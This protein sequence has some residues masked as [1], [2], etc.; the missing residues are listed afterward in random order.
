MNKKG[1][2]YILIEAI[3]AF[4]N[5]LYLLLYKNSF[6]DMKPLDING[7]MM[8]IIIVISII[9]TTP[10]YINRFGVI[11]FISLICLYLSGQANYYNEN[12][13]YFLYSFRNITTYGN[14]FPIIIIFI[15]AIIS[16]FIY[17]LF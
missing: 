7:L 12:Q 16:L 9:V 8:C 2:L 13:T 6:F 3:Y 11:I 14:K 15:I 10:P 4:I 1:L 17:F 5:I